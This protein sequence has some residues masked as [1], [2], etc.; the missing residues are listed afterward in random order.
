MVQGVSSLVKQ[1]DKGLVT[2]GIHIKEEDDFYLFAADKALKGLGEAG[3]PG[4]FMIDIFPRLKYIL[5]WFPG[6]TFKKKWAKYILD[7][8]EW[9]FQTTKTAM[10]QG[11]A[12]NCFVTSHLEGFKTLKGVPVDQEEVIKN[13]ARIVFTG[14]SDTTVNMMIT[15]IL[16]MALFP[17]IQQ[18]AQAELDHLLGHN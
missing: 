17:D 16:A 14:G 1:I 10:I 3:V 12:N 15:F 2:Y 9:P 6:A 18:K 13:T 11:A 8:K 5:Y 4:S 7:M